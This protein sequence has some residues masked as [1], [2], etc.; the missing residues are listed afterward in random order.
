[1]RDERLSAV[2]LGVTV[3]VFLVTIPLALLIGPAA[4]WWRLG[5]IPVEVRLGRREAAASG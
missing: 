1:M 5:L 4:M 3:A 2:Y